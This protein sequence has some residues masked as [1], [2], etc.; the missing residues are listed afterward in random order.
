MIW[1]NLPNNLESRVLESHFSSR[2]HSKLDIIFILL[3]VFYINKPEMAA[4]NFEGHNA[5]TLI[6][7]ALFAL[8]NNFKFI[9]PGR[10]LYLAKFSF[11]KIEMQK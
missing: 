8:L 11:Y 6:L 10:N 7:V 2:F 4:I 5:F 3:F 9:R 1:K